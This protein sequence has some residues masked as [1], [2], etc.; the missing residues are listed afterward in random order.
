MVAGCGRSLSGKYSLFLKPSVRDVCIKT[1]VRAARKRARAM[2]LAF[3]LFHQFLSPA[4]IFFS[5]T[6]LWQ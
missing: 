5:K 3:K 6:A 1:A 2:Q 4:A